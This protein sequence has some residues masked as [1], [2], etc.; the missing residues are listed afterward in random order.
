[1]VP[2][3]TVKDFAG[4][5][6]LK[7]WTPD[8]SLDASIQGG[9]AG[10]MLSW[11]MGRA[12]SGS[13]WMTIMSN[14]NVAAVALMAEVACVVLTEDVKPDEA[15]LAQAKERGLPLLGTPLSTYELSYRLE[16]LLAKNREP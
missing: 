1:M 6:P 5:L 16:A 13:V 3:M 4:S 14:Q 11:V 7:N 9:Y 8:V 15:L 12:A 2:V 10:D